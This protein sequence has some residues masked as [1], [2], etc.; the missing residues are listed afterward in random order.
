MSAFAGLFSSMS[1]SRLL[2]R[3]RSLASLFLSYGATKTASLHIKRAKQENVKT[4]LLP[5]FFSLLFTYHPVMLHTICFLE[6]RGINPKPIIYE[7]EKKKNNNNIKKKW[8]QINSQNRLMEKSALA[9]TH[10]HNL[11][12]LSPRIYEAWPPFFTWMNRMNEKKVSAP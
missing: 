8:A 9:L 1:L 5:L 12:W 4:S 2:S 6:P 11:K 7:D 10:M 3:A